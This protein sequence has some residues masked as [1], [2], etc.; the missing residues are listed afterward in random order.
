M[1]SSSLHGSLRRFRGC[2]CCCGCGGGCRL[3]LFLLHVI[4][5]HNVPESLQGLGNHFLF[6]VPREFLGPLQD[7]RHGPRR[8]K[9]HVERH[10]GRSP[11]AFVVVAFVVVAFVVAG[12]FALAEPHNAL[13]AEAR[14]GPPLDDVGP[15]V[16]DGDGRPGIADPEHFG[17]PEGSD[18][19]V[20][21]IVVVVVVIVIVVIVVALDHLDGFQPRRPAGLPGQIGIGVVG[22]LRRKGELDLALDLDQFV[23][24]VPCTTIA[25]VVVVVVAAAAAAAAKKHIVHFVVFHGFVFRQS[26]VPF[27]PFHPQSRPKSIPCTTDAV[28]V[29]VAA[30]IV[31]GSDAIPPPR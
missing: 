12:F 6:H 29:V 1:L 3:F 2:C 13:V 16:S 8:H 15:L 11:V 19:A 31:T 10:E 17:G 26:T 9:D 22:D 27:R 28:V 4:L 25:G 18:L 24:V 20:I 14:H 30:I 21:V 23:L 7:R 5:Q